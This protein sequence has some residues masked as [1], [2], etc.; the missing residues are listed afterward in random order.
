MVAAITQVRAMIQVGMSAEQIRSVTSGQSLRV[1]AGEPLLSVG[2][3]VGERERAPHVL[4]DRV[5]S[6]ATLG[7][8]WMLRGN[9]DGRGPEMIALARLACNVPDD[10]DD[11]PVCAAVAGLLDAYEPLAAADPDSRRP[12]ALLMLAASV[13]QTPDVPVPAGVAG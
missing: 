2:P 11:A 9:T 8:L 10:V 4:L 7:A 6:F 13:A 5:A 1:A 3:A 12:R